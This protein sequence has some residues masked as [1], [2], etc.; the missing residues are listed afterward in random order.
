M[1]RPTKSDAAIIKALNAHGGVITYAARALKIDRST[2]SV[3]INQSDTL[4][5]ARRE[6]LD[7]IL[8]EAEDVLFTKMREGNMS[9]VI[10]LLKCHGKARG[11]I[12]KPDTVSVNM[13]FKGVIAIPQRA[14]SSEEWTK[15]NA[16]QADYTVTDA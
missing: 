9:A 3:R 4:S 8:D 15:Q 14:E 10:F 12:E 16:L 5:E 6:A 13:D 2:L 11:Y 1:S 7:A